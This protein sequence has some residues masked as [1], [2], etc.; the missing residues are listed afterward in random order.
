MGGPPERR[1][2]AANR[3]LSEIGLDSPTRGASKRLRWMRVTD[4]AHQDV[5]CLNPYEFIRKYRCEHC[6]AV[7]MCSCDREFG[8]TFLP[9]Q[10]DHGTELDSGMEFSVTKGFQDGICQECRGLPPEPAPKAE[11][12]GRSSKIRR[13]YWREIFFETTKRFAAWADEAGLDRSRAQSEEREKY[14]E[15]ERAVVEELKTAHE[16]AP[17]YDYNEPSAA[18]VLTGY[19]VEVVDLRATYEQDESGGRRLSAEHGVFAKPEDLVAAHYET[20][21][22]QALVCE[23]RPFHV[24]FGVFMWLV[25]QDPADELRQL[26]GF[27][28]R[29]A[30]EDGRE[31]EQI[32][33][34]L[35]K[36]FG[37]PGYAVRR[38]AA[39]Q[40][41]FELLNDDLKWLFD[42]WLEPSADLRQYLWA[43]REHDVARARQILE[44]LSAEQVRAVLRYLVEAYWNRYV[45][46]PDLLVFDSERFFFA[47]V[48]G[49]GD[50]LSLD[51]KNWIEA[52]ADILHFPF[53]LVKIHRA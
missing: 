34:G 1:A 31:G 28:D 2:T 16:T 4:C 20:L 38:D 24:L 44:I 7:M 17:K 10:L 42:Y 29:A 45:G 26:S 40:E 25:I 11:L 36:D 12:Y 33:T 19:A 53:K 52:N 47:E 35:P 8:E 3:T 22:F 18:E 48:K 9:H 13:Y 21:G 30:F 51:Q 32:G 49:S 23:S 15:V 50:G 27:G 6:G 37:K 14:E 46:W 39:L 41:H 43:H 5:S